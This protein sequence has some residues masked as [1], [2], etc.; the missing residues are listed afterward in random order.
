MSTKK[1]EETMPDCSTSGMGFART[2]NTQTASESCGLPARGFGTTDFGKKEETKQ[3]D[4]T[5]VDCSTA[6]MGFA[7]TDRTA[8]APEDCAFPNK[9]FGTT[10]FG[11]NK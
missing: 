7:R 11:K 9:G 4:N 2:G 3:D 10:D 6:G 5:P 1:E 8:I